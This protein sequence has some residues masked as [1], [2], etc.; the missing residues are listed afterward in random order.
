MST[1]FVN[2]LKP[3]E[4]YTHTHTHTHTCSFLPSLKQIGTICFL[5]IFFI[6]PIFA[7]TVTTLPNNALCN[8]TNLGTESGSADI[9]VVWTPNTIN[10]T[11]YT[12]YGE[13][14]VYSSPT[15]CDYGDTI[16]LPQTNPSRAGYAFA[17]WKLKTC[18]VPSSNLATNGTNGYGHGWWNNADYC[19]NIDSE[20]SW[21]TVNCST[22]PDLS[23]NQWKTEF[24]YGTVRGIASCQ[25]TVPSDILYLDTNVNAVL[26]GEMD[27]ATF[28][29]EYTA[30]AEQEKGA[31]AQQAF[32]AFV[33]GDEATMMTLYYQLLSLPGSTNYSTNDTGQYCFC[34]A[35]H[36]TANN[37]GQCPLSSPAWVFD[38]DNGSAANCAD[39]CASYC[40]N[41]VRFYSNIRAAVLGPY[42]AQ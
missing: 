6:S 38:G 20:G 24:N 28:L 1:K 39:Y 5:T 31:I 32:T 23:L 26:K 25:S 3:A 14:G 36:Y 30:L 12:G 35:T 4:T 27:P 11:W 37:S 9:E 10:T 19:Y 40:A 13:N 2:R 15:T 42:V 21:N 17:G 41:D 22:V 29:S 16:N 18:S 34:Q 7:D 8:E 33:Q